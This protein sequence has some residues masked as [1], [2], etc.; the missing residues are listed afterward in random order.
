MRTPK[1]RVEQTTDKTWVKKR[2]VP[3]KLNFPWLGF[4]FA[5]YFLFT[6]WYAVD[7]QTFGTIPFLL[8]YFCGYAYAV[9]MA[10]AQARASLSGAK[11]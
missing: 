1:Y 11:K 8:I 5:A 2:Y 7:S 10:I 6:I 3:R 9:A 4:L